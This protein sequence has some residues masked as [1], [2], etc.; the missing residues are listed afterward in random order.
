VRLRLI[1]F[2]VFS[3][4]AVL[5][6]VALATWIISDALDREIESVRDKHLVIARNVGKALERYALDLK[7]GF[8]L[9][10][11]LPPGDYES[12]AV[13]NFMMSLNF[14]HFCI[15]D[16]R[17]GEIQSA[18]VTDARPWPGRVPPNRLKSFRRLLG[19]EEMVFSPVMRS[20]DG[21]PVFYLLRSR[22][23]KLY[24]AAVS[25]EYVVAQGT[26][27]AFGDKGHAA[28]VD[29]TGRIMAHP[30][31]AWRADM[32]N[33]A[34]VAPVQRMMSRQ[35]GTMMFFSPALKAD[36][37]SGYTFVPLTGW[38]VMIPQPLS[39]VRS[40]ALLIQNSAIGIAV[41]GIIS[42]ALLSWFLSGYLT[43]SLSSVVETTQRMAAGDL[44]ARVEVD[45]GF[46]TSE[47]Q[48]L[49]NSF[50]DMADEIAKTN[51]NLSQA[52]VEANAANRAKSEFLA[53]MSHDLRT[54]LNA[55]I[56]FSEAMQSGI[57]GP[58]NNAKYGEYLDDIIQSGNML[59]SLINDILDLSK[60]EAGRY[61]LKESD[62]ELSAFLE[63]QVE[64]AAIQANQDGVV[65]ELSVEDR[66]PQLRCDERTLM[67]V[68]N[69]LLSNAVK[70]SD[71]GGL[72]RISAR[73]G[74][75]GTMEIEFSDQGIGM[76]PRD[77]DEVLQPFSQADSL[78]SRQHEGTGLGLP[79]CQKFVELHGG[80][81]KI[82]SELGVGTTVT[83]SFPARRV[84]A[85]ATMK[86][87]GDGAKGQH[88]VKQYR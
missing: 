69:N 74:T 79:I 32:K 80:T 6:V 43:R 60:I 25:T 52:V 45:T 38:G 47:F 87:K 7:N 17:T 56:G 77:L 63:N 48:D 24:I 36:M 23:E 42:A 18:I 4:I 53:T 10:A 16:A 34:K 22:G 19:Q 51:N 84:L 85:E 11:S 27:V 86:W 64:L 82:N 40:A 44:D 58:I 88:T 37:V 46:I 66:L 61:E 21:H 57:Y 70:F 73:Q 30:L 76:S 41:A 71:A 81:L 15:A 62:I 83:I 54:P 39:E 2:L 1:I 35:T 75:A 28:I 50:N 65:L 8:D 78:K 20:P 33:I 14:E 49:G 9:V 12:E 13:R 59:L 31:S 68:V 5:P 26:A 29:R 67:Q 55:I 3:G 72:V